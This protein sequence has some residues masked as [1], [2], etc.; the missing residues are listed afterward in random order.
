MDTRQLTH[1]VRMK[2]WAQVLHRR[3][4]SGQTIRGFCRAEGICE[5][6]YYYW[7]KRLRQTAGEAF[8][9][10]GEPSAPPMLPSGPVFAAL[11]APRGNAC[12]DGVIRIEIGGAVV[13]IGPGADIDAALSV[14]R[15]LTG[16]C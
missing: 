15:M 4:E 12:A 10:Q 2:H 6:T 8:A 1:E 3:R 13:E 16:Q 9:G 11:P 7:Q 14:L 5:K